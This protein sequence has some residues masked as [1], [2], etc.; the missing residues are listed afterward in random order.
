M[1]KD[2]ISVSELIDHLK[3]CNQ[4]ARVYISKKDDGILRGATGLYNQKMVCLLD[5]LP[6]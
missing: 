6:F 4:N 1:K 5:S 2:F 3:K